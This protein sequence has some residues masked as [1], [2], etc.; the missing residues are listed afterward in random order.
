[1]AEKIKLYMG[2]PSTGDRSDAQCYAL[3]KI[4]KKYS[5][6]IEFI[7]PDVLIGR[8]FHD[9]ARNAIV[10]EFK[11][12]GADILWFLDSDIA[13]PINALDLI[14]EHGDKWEAAGIAYPIFLQDKILLTVYKK[15]PTKKD[16]LTYNES[17]PGKGTEFVQGLA[18]GCLFLKRS[19]ID[20][21][22]A[23]YFEFEYDEK[24]RMMTVG[25]DLGFCL[26]VNK[27][28]VRFF[29]DHSMVCKHYKRVDL[30]DMNNYAHMVA[31]WHLEQY[32]AEI[33]SKVMLAGQ[34]NAMLVKKVEFLEQKLAAVEKGRNPSGLILP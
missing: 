2:I 10:E 23:P 28:G 26:R 25:E 18:T 30:L 6:R 24:S 7:Y 5:D 16:R 15:H 27:L 31:R 3:R 12:S 32:D 4:E 9:F 33:K 19:L 11:A 29:T 20:K 34:Q 14:T 8:F 13:P 1:M 17:D 21:L 22:E